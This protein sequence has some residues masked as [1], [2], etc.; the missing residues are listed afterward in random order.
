MEKISFKITNNENE[1]VNL[2]VNKNIKIIDLKKIIMEKFKISAIYIDLELL[3]ERPI[4]KFGKFNLEPG[5][6]PQSFDN[7]KIEDFAFGNEILSIKILNNNNY[8]YKQK[9]KNNFIKRRRVGNKE[10]KKQKK[11]EDFVLN[12]NDFPPLG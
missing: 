3:L 6:L 12:K 8:T 1:E 9:K 2:E 10:R 5:I 4:R 7:S 11:E